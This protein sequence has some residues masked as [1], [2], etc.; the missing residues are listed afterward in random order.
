MT[1]PLGFTIAAFNLDRVK[2][3]LAKQAAD[4]GRPKLRAKRRQGTWSQAVEDGATKARGKAPP[5]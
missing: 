1:M 5:G 4:E 2:R 3:Y